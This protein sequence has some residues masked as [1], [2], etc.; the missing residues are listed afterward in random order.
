MVQSLVP[1]RH[2]E[3]EVID[4]NN[5]PLEA[6]ESEEDYMAALFSA[7][8][9]RHL[10]LHER[11]DLID[12]VSAQYEAWRWLVSHWAQFVTLPKVFSI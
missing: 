9:E 8:P 12:T 6:R 11:I 2:A 5:A 1:R 4:R 10:S 3:V 7:L